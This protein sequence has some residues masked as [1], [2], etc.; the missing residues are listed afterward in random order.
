MKTDLSATHRP[1]PSLTKGLAAAAYWIEKPYD[2]AK[3]RLGSKI[4]RRD[5]VHVVPYRGH[6]TPRE[7]FLKGRVL[8]DEGIRHA[9]GAT[10]WQSLVNSYKRFETDEVPGA[11]LRA[12]IAGPGGQDVQQEV[13]TDEEG[14]FDVRLRPGW[15]LPKDR[16][17]HD[18]ELE[19]L[20]DWDPEKDRLRATGAV[21][22]PSPEARFVVVS[23]MD[24][25]VL[26]TGATDFWG[27]VRRTAFEDVH[28]RLPFE[29]VA[30]FYR[31]LQRG[32]DGAGDDVHNPLFYV[33][34][35]P[36]NLYDLLTEFLRLHG[37]PAGPLF[38][39]DLGVDREKFIKASHH[40]HK[41]AQIEG[42]LALYPDLPFVL[43]GDSGQEDPEIYRQAVADFPGRIKAIYIRDVTTPERDRAVH[44]IA[45]EVEA[46]GVPMRLVKD[47]VA[48]AEHAIELG[49]IAEGALPDVRASKAKDEEA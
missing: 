45:A 34:S 6:G 28:A 20:G 49:L 19:L 40:E 29:G 7:V 31:A 42:L 9:E 43:V 36:W 38:L 44:A 33:S 4:G 5:P 16:L 15:G 48:A 18:V 12:R 8:Q 24:D 32:V 10:R 35:S 30:A 14:Y 26:Q 1:M 22:V 13:T 17:W 37:I 11:R 25:T 46:E 3:A 39:R 27:M 2:W 21:L 41:L 23:D 47:T